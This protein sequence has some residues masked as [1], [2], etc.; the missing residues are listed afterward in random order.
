MPNKKQLIILID[1]E[2]LERFKVAAATIDRSMVWLANDL[3]DRYL[4]GKEPPAD[5]TIPQTA[6]EAIAAIGRRLEEVERQLPLLT[7][8]SVTAITEKVIASW[9]IK[10]LVMM[11]VE[12][13][14]NNATAPVPEEERNFMNPSPPEELA[15]Y[16]PDGSLLPTGKEK[17]KLST[18]PSLNK[19]E[20]AMVQRLEANPDFRTAAE[21][22]IK[23][24]G[25]GAD[26]AQRLLEA[27]Y[28]T[29][30]GTAHDVA[31]IT[32]IKKAIAHLAGG[33]AL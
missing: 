15:S 11:E 26:I 21:A 30:K 3:I 12:R 6:I 5:A 7:V 1:Q 33:D 28:G 2:K 32:R 25:N 18:T 17:S 20:L 9:S 10:E 27:G 22:A 14:G 31:V 16:W 13:L 24:G 19:D 8:E 29:K 23:S 4:E